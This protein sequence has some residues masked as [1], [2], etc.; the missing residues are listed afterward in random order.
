MCHGMHAEKEGLDTLMIWVLRQGGNEREMTLLPLSS[1]RITLPPL[2]DAISR[3]G[4]RQVV[5]V[6]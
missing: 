3:Q 5:N 6:N 4:G 1:L 2:H